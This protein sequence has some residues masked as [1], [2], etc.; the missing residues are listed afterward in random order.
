ML[1][2]ALTGLLVG[3]GYLAGGSSLAL[4]ALSLAGVMNFLAYWFS[5]KLALRMAGAH[6]M[7]AASRR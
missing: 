2:G 6:A 7:L 4:V 5:D 1:M 3:L